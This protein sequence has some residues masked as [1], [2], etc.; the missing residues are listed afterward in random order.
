MYGYFELEVQ[1]VG[2]D[3]IT[4]DKGKY[5]KFYLIN[6]RDKTDTNHQGFSTLELFEPVSDWKNLLENADFKPG[7]TFKLE[8][9]FANYRFRPVKFVDFVK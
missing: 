2:Y 6:H 4:S 7:C 9:Y 5:V 8:G 3:F 1:L